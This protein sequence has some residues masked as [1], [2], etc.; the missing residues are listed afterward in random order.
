MAAL[1]LLDWTLGVPGAFLWM[2]AS[3]TLTFAALAAW[4]RRRVP[5]AGKPTTG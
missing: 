4:E 5:A 1:V 3:G 2:L